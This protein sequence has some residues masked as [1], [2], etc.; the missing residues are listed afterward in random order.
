MR[1][2]GG[3]GGLEI[4]KSAAPSFW[5]PRLLALSAA[6]VLVGA[7][8]AAFFPCLFNG[9]VSDDRGYILSNPAVRDFTLSGFLR[10]WTDTFCFSYVPL[11]MVS[12]WVDSFFW[13]RNP[14]PFHAV[15]LLLHLAVCFLVWLF[16]QRMS[17]SRLIGFLAAILFGLH[18]L[19]VEA[20]AW[21][22]SRK[23]LL[24]TAFFLL[25]LILYDRWREKGGRRWYA[26][27]LGCAVCSF[28]S[29]PSAVTFPLAAL[30]VEYFRGRPFDRTLWVGLSPFFVLSAAGSAVTLVTQRALIGA[31]PHSLVLS[32]AVPLRGLV[33]YLTKTLLPVRLSALYPFPDPACLLSGL[34]VDALLLTTV[35]AAAAIAMRTPWKRTVAFSLLFFIATIL[36]SLKAVPFAV[37]IAADRYTYLPSVG[38]M[39]LAAA[40]FARGLRPDR[41]TMVRIATA[42]LLFGSA[43]GMGTLSSS[44]CA[45]WKDE[46]TLYT[47]ACR[48]FPHAMTYAFRGLACGLA[49]DFRHAVAD[50]STALILDPTPPLRVR[51]LGNRAVAYG[52]L[53][54]YDRAYADYAAALEVAADNLWAA[55]EVIEVYRKRGM[56]SAAL[57]RHAEAIAD[58][59]AA[60]ALRPNEAP[61]CGLRANSLAAIGNYEAAIDDYDRAIRANPTD[62]VFLCNRGLAKAA[63]GDH[64]GAIA[65]FT[66]A[67]L[68]NPAF[69]HAYAFRARSRS[70]IGDA[71]G[72]RED[73]RQAG[74]LGLELPET[75]LSPIP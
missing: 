30:C 67:L 61:L 26:T 16:V 3:G 51:I 57:G 13:G 34:P 75:F 5:T 68:R 56:L 9:F 45:V 11:T 60:L 44:R 72:A 63:L 43:I 36:P 22:S 10:L 1:P 66:A 64:Q 31:E 35:A 53:G 25:G 49:G 6:I 39:Y 62:V 41:K 40:V 54:Q 37:G 20:V 4:R 69:N 74:R 33:I 70:A 28:L 17:G 21:V 2:A 15:N 18:P 12:F 42:A 65:D 59:T 55:P 32:I 50:L 52:E 24:S 14:A 23:D 71:Q 8:S 73:A 38:L 29:K 47:D 46:V 48:K 27:A 58:F 19:R 7:V